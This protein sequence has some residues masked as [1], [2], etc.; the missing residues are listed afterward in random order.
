MSGTYDIVAYG[1]KTDGSLCTQAIQAAI[2]ACF[3]A[4]GG[5]VVVPTGTYLTGGVR[6]RSNVTL[7]LMKNAVLLGSLCPEDYMG[8]IDD[9]VEPIPMEERDQPVPTIH[10][11]LDRS[12]KTSAYPYSRWNNAI[13]RAIKAKNIAIIGEMGSE[14]NGQIC[15]DPLGENGERGP[16]PINMWYCE[17]VELKGYTVRDSANWAHAI[18]NSRNIHIDGVTVLAGHDGFDART[19]DDILVENCVFRTGDDC[20]AGFDNINMTIRN[21]VFDGACSMLRIGGTNILVERCL[22][23]SPATYAWRGSL[24][25]WER[26]NRMPTTP[27]ARHEANRVFMY[28]CDYRAKVRQTP[29]NICFRDCYFKNPKQLMR[30]DWGHKWACNRSLA[31]VRYENCIFDGLIKPTELNCPEEEPVSVHFKNCTMVASKG[32]EALPFI[33]GVNVKQIKLERVRFE[34]F[35]DP[36]ILCDSP[37]EII[38]E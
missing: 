30:V 2:D 3:L 36:R 6:L 23:I 10:P 34:G 20:I 17:N 19:C 4:G 33:T 21:C 38:V 24:S 14:I 7:H 31:D 1:A 15:Y 32:G 26:A 18:Q 22:G 35:D 29:G 11:D 9:T 12:K 8:Y 25:K 13:I 27:A 28:Y 16:H 5:E 37:V